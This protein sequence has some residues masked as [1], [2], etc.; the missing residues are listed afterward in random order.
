MSYITEEEFEKKSSV[1]KT[2]PAEEHTSA[3]KE[4][5]IEYVGNIYT[6]EDDN[7]TLE[8]IITTMAEEFPEF[9]WALAEEN[10]VRGYEQ[11][12]LDVDSG[13]ELAAAAEQKS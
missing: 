7:V 5:I 1:L 11:A 13:K 4:H 6:P 12:L 8:M 10:W 9:V 3:L 2:I